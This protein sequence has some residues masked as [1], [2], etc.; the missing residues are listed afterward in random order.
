MDFIA[1]WAEG[2]SWFQMVSQI[3][4]FATAVTIA[5]PSRWHQKNGVEVKWYK[6][7]SKGLNFLAGNIFK[8]KNHDDHSKRN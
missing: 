1:N 3:V 2:Q 5:I 4:A 6:W 8:N 7:L